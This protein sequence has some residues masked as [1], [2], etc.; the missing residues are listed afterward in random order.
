MNPNQEHSELK[1]LILENQRLLAENNMLLKKM[2]RSAVRHLWFNVAWIVLFFVLPL[3]ALYKLAIPMYSSFSGE[4]M[5]VDES[6]K[7]MQELKSLLE[8]QR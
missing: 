5:S 8:N 3:I 4:S 1:E 2:H 6:L 7:D